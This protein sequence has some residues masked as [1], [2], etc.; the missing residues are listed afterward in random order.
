VFRE[1][2]DF[3]NR[4]CRAEISVLTHGPTG[5]DVCATERFPRIAGDRSEWHPNSRKE[6]NCRKALLGTT[7]SFNKALAPAAIERAIGIS[8]NFRGR[9]HAELPQ[10]RKAFREHIFGSIAQGQ[11]D[12][13]RLVVTGFVLPQVA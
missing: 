8:K 2:I 9:D 3:G 5:D 11:T 6:P 10:A 1:R 13:Q 4:S 7:D 12:E